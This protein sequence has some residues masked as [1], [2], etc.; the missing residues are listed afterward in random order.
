MIFILL[1]IIISIW[2]TEAATKNSSTECKY[3]IT[4]KSD[5]YVLTQMLK[6]PAPHPEV[7]V[8]TAAGSKLIEGLFDKNRLH[9]PFSQIQIS[10]RIREAK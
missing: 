10:L 2:K 3:D 5:P 1:V 6:G 8:R 7:D 4:S 9:G